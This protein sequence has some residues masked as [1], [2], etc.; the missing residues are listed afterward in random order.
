[1]SV[2]TTNSGSSVSTGTMTIS[3]HTFL[4]G[5]VTTMTGS[6]PDIGNYGKVNQSSGGLEQTK[7]STSVSSK[8]KDPNDGDCS[9]L[10]LTEQ[11]VLVPLLNIWLN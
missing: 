5:H 6:C 1:M 11:R 10:E 4:D 9:L 3:D 8:L 2:G 7:T